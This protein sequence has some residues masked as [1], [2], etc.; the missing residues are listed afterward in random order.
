[1]AE[2]K[3][4]GCNRKAWKKFEYC[5]FH[6][7]SKD[8]D[9]DLFWNGIDRM[10]KKKDYNF[11]GFYFIPRK[12]EDF[13]DLREIEFYGT[14]NISFSKAEFY[15]DVAFNFCIFNGNV[16]FSEIKVS[17][18]SSIS[19]LGVKFKKWVHFSLTDFPKLTY[20]TSAVFENKAIFLGSR[21]QGK[22]FFNDSRFLEEVDFY[23]TKFMR[24]MTGKFSGAE[25]ERTEFIENG[26]W[27]NALLG[28]TNFD[29]TFFKE[30][31]RHKFY[32]T[33]LSKVEFYD[34]NIVA[35]D[36]LD[37]VWSKI[38]GRKGLY[39]E[40][41]I[42]NSNKSK[43]VIWNQQLRSKD[44]IFSEIETLYRQLKINYENKRNYPDAGD[45]YIGEMEMRRRNPKTSRFDRWIILPFYK[46]V[47][48]YGE[49]YKRTLY[50][51]GG[52]ILLSAYSLMFTGMKVKER[53]I[54]YY[55]S[56][57]QNPNGLKDF[58]ELVNIVARSIIL[59]P[60]AFAESTSLGSR[61]IL[62][63]TT[64]FGIL[65]IALFTLA[66]RRRFRR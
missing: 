16:N 63:F 13:I 12:G 45:F 56:L 4:E 7:P 30:P 24:D 14:F 28:E 10:M 58:G 31:K 1:M 9:A 53:I 5:I 37:P 40:V 47:S 66:L 52:L 54:D 8:K 33:D 25:F 2:C 17:K 61:I 59:Q 42:N 60:S 20:F 34:T 22:V 27:R 18:D 29:K 23:E 50:W 39:N 48:N 64:I 57:P 11:G 21:F 15:K 32:H 36:F 35:L 44:E 62:T 19:F 49:D 65:L 41:L 55:P 51:I 43:E 26:Y 38:N 46:C 3:Y 6:E